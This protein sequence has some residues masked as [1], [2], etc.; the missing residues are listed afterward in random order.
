MI[1]SI[2]LYQLSFPDLG[3]LNT[4]FAVLLFSSDLYRQVLPIKDR[5]KTF[6]IAFRNT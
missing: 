2:E 5:R 3:Q 6:L 4:I 1:G